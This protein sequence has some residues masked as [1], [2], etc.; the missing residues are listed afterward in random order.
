MLPPLAGKAAD[1]LRLYPCGDGGIYIHTIR[2]DGESVTEMLDESVVF[3]V[4]EPSDVAAIKPQPHV[5]NLA[6]VHR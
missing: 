5:A 4:G 6:F 2:G 1:P 3:A